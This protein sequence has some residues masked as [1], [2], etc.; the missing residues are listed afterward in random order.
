[1]H[2]HVNIS[3]SRD[4]LLQRLLGLAKEADG[5]IVLGRTY[6]DNKSNLRVLIRIG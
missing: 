1:M 2:R 5:V 4:R 6:F 3:P